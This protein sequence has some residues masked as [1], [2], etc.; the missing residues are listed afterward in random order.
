MLKQI[1]MAFATAAVIGQVGAAPITPTFGT[2]GNLAGATFG[3][4]DIPTDPTA[5]RTITVG[6][7]TI[8]LGLTAHPRYSNPS[9]TNDGLGTYFATPGL[10]DG[11]V[12]N[13][14]LGA[15]WNFAFYVS[16]AG[17]GDLGDYSFRL[18]YDLDPGVGT[19]SSSMGVI[20]LSAVAPT[21]SLVQDSQNAAFGFLCGPAI[22]TVLAPPSGVG[23][24]PFNADA[25][26][27][28]SFA[29][30][31]APLASTTASEYGRVAINV[32]VIP[33]PGT[34][35]LLGLAL[36]GMVAVRKRF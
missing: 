30:I 8:T 11:L 25:F 19:D 22:P 13:P 36:L 24:C 9:L 18:L 3:G 1:T 15:T 31:A 27:E 34:L 23:V 6:S 21:A 4:T 5:I 2:F 17:G 20:N 10:N 28:Y 32:N 7:D 33:E 29:L 14:T 35:G 16:I 26:G 12:G